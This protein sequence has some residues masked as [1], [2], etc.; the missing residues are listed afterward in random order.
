MKDKPAPGRMQGHSAKRPKPSAQEKHV[1]FKSMDQVENR[2]TYVAQLKKQLSSLPEKE[3]GKFYF[4]DGLTLGGAEQAVL[5]VGD[6]KGSVI[7]ELK[8]K[9][10]IRA[11]GNCFREG[12]VLNLTLGA[13]KMPE[14]RLKQIFREAKTFGFQLVEANLNQADTKAGAPS[15]EAKVRA[16]VGSLESTFDKVKG[17]ISD[18]NRKALRIQ[19]GQIEDALGAKK[20]DEVRK[21]A[22][23]LEEDMTDFAQQADPGYGQEDP[24]DK[25]NATQRWKD[26][27]ARF[28]KA[29]SRLTDD[30]RKAIRE[31]W[32]TAEDK[33][34]ANDWPAT[35]KALEAVD[36]EVIRAVK[37]ALND[38]A[39]DATKQQTKIDTGL[40]AAAQLL[41]TQLKQQADLLENLRKRMLDEMKE[42]DQIRVELREEEA[43]QPP[44]GGAALTDIKNRLDAKKKTLDTARKALELQR[45]AMAKTEGELK[46]QNLLSDKD[47]VD[48]LERAK[49]A[50]A[51]LEDVLQSTPIDQAREALMA[52]AK[53]MT[54][55]AKWREERLKV[56]AAGGT[57][58]TSRH[59]AQTGFER[60]ARR[61]ATAESV[62]PDQVDNPSGSAQVIEWNKV[63]FVYTVQDGKREIKDRLK[64]ATQ[65]VGSATAGALPTEIGSMWATPVLEKEAYELA[66]SHA[67]KLKGYTQYKKE[68]TRRAPNPW[69]AFLS[70]TF[71]VKKEPGWGYAVKHT[72]AHISIPDADAVLHD[73]EQG[74]IDLDQMF[75]R[76]NTTLH[77]VDG[78]AKLIPYAV[79]VLKRS[80]VTAGWTL[81]TQYPDS[82]K[83]GVKWEPEKQWNKPNIE[84]RETDG[85]PVT[86]YAANALP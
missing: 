7:T 19:F 12:H 78:G 22:A 86:T 85:G 32:G 18:E 55:A 69:A 17:K 39:A 27:M 63:K 60:Q 81:L 38:A 47:T 13:G 62:T 68:P 71:V 14:S 10:K 79:V 64:V 6:V 83:T 26:T 74:K 75:K 53:K 4:F 51:A 58:A 43:R 82:T 80:S 41:V 3:L 76:L 57:H 56:E 46:A 52:T 48:R 30:E 40:G 24:R 65:L 8:S 44:S 35:I 34:K 70:A 28:D 5:L 9:A 42:V 72:G 67:D 33:L 16:I 15:D 25:A 11:T 66:L 2:D 31:L 1:S 20:W 49:K 84:L 45:T 50:M 77:A 54:D 23:G 37:A 59:G 36:S 29:K 21:L 61:A 73:F